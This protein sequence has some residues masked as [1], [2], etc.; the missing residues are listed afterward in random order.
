MRRTHSFE[1]VGLGEFDEFP[2][3]VKEAVYPTVNKDGMAVVKKVLTQGI[4]SEYGWFDMNG[5]V[6]SKEEVFTNLNGQFVNKVERTKTIKK[7]DIVDFSDVGNL[8]ESDTSFLLPKNETTLM[9]FKELVPDGKAMFFKYKK[10]S[11]GMKW[12]KSYVYLNQDELWMI[13]GLGKKSEALE[14]F[15][16]SKKISK[17]NNGMPDEVVVSA[18]SVEPTLD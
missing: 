8:L 14:Q 12:V 2:A 4:S 1:I 5:K 9:R 7:Y 11:V 16:A 15:K 17:G 3:K 6:Y 18:D 10:S 13:T